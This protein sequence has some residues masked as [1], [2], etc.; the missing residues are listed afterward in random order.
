MGE[1]RHEYT[2]HD[3]DLRFLILEVESHV[4]G[5]VTHGVIDSKE[6]KSCHQGPSVED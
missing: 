5:N 1:S 4:C 3:S 6:L 2:P